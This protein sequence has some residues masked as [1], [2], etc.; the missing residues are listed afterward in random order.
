MFLLKFKEVEQQKTPFNYLTFRMSDKLYD[1]RQCLIGITFKVD[2]T[3][4]SCYKR[5]T[6][7]SIN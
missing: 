3:S 2:A 5:R 7:M 1:I 6:M 4:L